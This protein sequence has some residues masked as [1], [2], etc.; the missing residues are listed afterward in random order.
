MEKKTWSSAWDDRSGLHKPLPRSVV[1]DILASNRTKRGR[2]TRTR[3]GYMIG[4]DFHLVEEPPRPR[5]CSCGQRIRTDIYIIHC[6][7]C[8]LK[9]GVE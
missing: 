7:P 2:V 3:R 8:F 6:M 5:Y 9:T 1:A 4:H